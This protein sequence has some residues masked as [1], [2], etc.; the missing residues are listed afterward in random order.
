MEPVR[1]HYRAHLVIPLNVLR[2]FMCALVRVLSFMAQI[3]VRSPGREN[4]IFKAALGKESVDGVIWDQRRLRL[5]GVYISLY[6]FTNMGLFDFTIK[7]KP[8][9]TSGI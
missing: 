9:I 6:A 4:Y 8:Y 3:I 1:R 7:I 2:P 5:F